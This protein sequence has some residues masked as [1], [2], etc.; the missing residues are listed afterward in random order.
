[1]TTGGYPFDLGLLAVRPPTVM[2]E[3]IMKQV[4]ELPP[5][6]NVGGRRI[7]SRYWVTAD[8]TGRVHLDRPQSYV[9]PEWVM[10]VTR[11]SDPDDLADELREFVP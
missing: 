2:A 10:T 4:A 6:M 8:H 9:T 11:Q 1:M 5:R 7:P 3:R